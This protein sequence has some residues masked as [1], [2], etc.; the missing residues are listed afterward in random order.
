MEPAR[1]GEVRTAARVTIR[2][3]PAT[4]VRMTALRLR[5]DLDGRYL[6]TDQKAPPPDRDEET[7][8]NNDEAPTSVAG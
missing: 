3:P 2:Q 4:R 7:V 1:I 5:A 6:A 8:R